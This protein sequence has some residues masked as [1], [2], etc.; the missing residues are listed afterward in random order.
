MSEPTPTSPPQQNGEIIELRDVYKA[1]GPKQVLDGVSLK[2]REGTSAVVL[3]GSG[4]G[5]SVLIKH[6]VRLLT[7]DQGEVWVKGHRVD[8][9][10][11]DELDHLRLNIG[12]LFQGGALFDSM[13]VFENL[14][15]ILR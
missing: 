6:V 4:T 10:E 13:T 8:Q 2:V 3:G 1:F 5:K 9:M 7:P 11:G 12:Y 14:D 15:F